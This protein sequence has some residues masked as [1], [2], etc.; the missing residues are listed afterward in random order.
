MILVQQYAYVLC[1]MFYFQCLNWN[2]SIFFL[3][4]IG[5]LL[6]IADRSLVA[7]LSLL[8]S[9][10]ELAFVLSDYFKEEYAMR[11]VF[12]LVGKG[13]SGVPWIRLRFISK[14]LKQHKGWHFTPEE[15]QFLPTSPSRRILHYGGSFCKFLNLYQSNHHVYYST[16]FLHI[17]CFYMR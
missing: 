8:T 17:K 11:K 14:S 5:V 10:Y 1:S 4:S 2:S 7:W 12:E 9:I 16:S 15:V 6:V 3:A 13:V